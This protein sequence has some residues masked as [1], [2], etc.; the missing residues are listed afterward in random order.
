[1]PRV[2]EIAQQWFKA[3]GARFAG[4]VSFDE[5]LSRH[6][7]Y[8]IGGPASVL[9]Q[10]KGLGDLALLTEALRECPVPLFVM[11]AGSN[12][13]ASD[14]GFQ[15]VVVKTGKLNPEISP[16]GAL[17]RAGAGVV[18]S[19][20]LRRA[21]Q[22]GWGGLEFLTGIPG[23]MGGVVRMNGGTHLGESKD[24]IRRV[25]YV[26]LLGAGAGSSVVVEKPSE[27]RFEYRKNL[28]LP[29]GGVV[30]S[31]DWEV[32]P[33]DP[34][35]VKERVDSTLARRKA[36]QPL[37]YPSCGSVFKNPRAQGL[38][39]W[40]VID[41]L[42]LRGHRIGNARIAEK[43]CNWILNLGDARASDVRALIDLVKARALEELGVPMEEEVRMLG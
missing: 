29:E 22:E 5:P 26:P 41:K 19:S 42:G 31:V 28:F 3:H 25:E 1:M 15:G 43:H 13:L 7:Y 34:A 20:L 35:R 4:T 17:V 27:L 18:V 32:S 37:D 6:T 33:D 30:W 36:T 2:V 11:G 8:R 21:S 23:M 16:D 10:P 38:E 39:A 12:L 14:E 40:Q 9:V 24:R